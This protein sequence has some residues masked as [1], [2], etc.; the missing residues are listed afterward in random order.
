[1]WYSFGKK[2]EVIPYNEDK[3]PR[4]F[5]HKNAILLPVLIV[6]FIAN[7]FV[8]DQAIK[9]YRYADYLPALSIILLVATCIILL[10]VKWVK[11]N[12]EVDFSLLFLLFL[13]ALCAMF[14]YYV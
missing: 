8:F 13:F 5:R 14:V 3:R 6:A 1:M 9:D 10:I 4:K 12:R 2:W 11:N 7:T